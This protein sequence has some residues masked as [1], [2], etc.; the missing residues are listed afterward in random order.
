MEWAG[1]NLLYMVETEQSLKKEELSIR[2]AEQWN[3]NYS[4]GPK[5]LSTLA[6]EEDQYVTMP[7]RTH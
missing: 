5:L 1:V 4:K 6:P 2:R 3:R 7:D